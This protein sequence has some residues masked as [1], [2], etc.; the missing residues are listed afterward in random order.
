MPSAP[1]PIA[2]AAIRAKTPIGSPL[3][4]QGWAQV[5]IG[6]R[7]SA[8]FSATVERLRFLQRIQD[9]IETAIANLR[10]EGA[11]IGGG[12]GAFQ[13]RERFIAE[14]QQIAR[15]EGLAPQALG[16]PQ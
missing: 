12:P 2:V 7:E 6:L 13:T 5:P 16:Q 15:E 11:G 1:N 8:Q 3:N 9:R 14:L 10:R 4:T